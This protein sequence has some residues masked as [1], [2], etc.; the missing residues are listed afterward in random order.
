MLFS[1]PFFDL[2]ARSPA[3]LCGMLIRNVKRSEGGS[4]GGSGQLDILLLA[5]FP[6]R[7]PGWEWVWVGNF[8]EE[9]RQT[10]PVHVLQLGSRCAT[11]FLDMFFHGYQL[12]FE[13][14][15]CKVPWGCQTAIFLRVILQDPKP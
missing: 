3:E 5:E 15:V 11:P 8:R 2:A 13:L 4:S 1:V 7:V 12:V 6:L 10:A 9:G 14:D